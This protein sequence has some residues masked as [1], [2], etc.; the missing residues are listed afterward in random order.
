MI[1]LHASKDEKLVILRA[2]EPVT[3]VLSFDY[4]LTEVHPHL[5]AAVFATTDHPPHRE[6]LVT[7]WDSKQDP[8]LGLLGPSLTQDEPEPVLVPARSLDDIEVDF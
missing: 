7:Q 1:D 2:D 4:K 8:A 6:T 5:V 3:L